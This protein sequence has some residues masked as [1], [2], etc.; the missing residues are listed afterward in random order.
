MSVS[1]FSYIDC[2][3]F[4]TSIVWHNF[5]FMGHLPSWRLTSFCLTFIT[6]S[7]NNYSVEL[8]G[9]SCNKYNMLSLKRKQTFSRD[10]RVFRQLHAKIFFSFFGDFHSFSKNTRETDSSKLLILVRIWVYYGS[11]FTKHPRTH[12]LNILLPRFL[13][14]LSRKIEIN[15]NLFML[16]WL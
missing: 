9:P 7:M 11:S 12:Q 15:T 1:V 8:D 2:V 10:D 13:A 16:L 6:T 14:L 3:I 4:Y 5:S